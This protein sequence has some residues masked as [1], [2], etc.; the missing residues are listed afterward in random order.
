MILIQL[1]TQLYIYE[2]ASELNVLDIGLKVKKYI[3]DGVNTVE[4]E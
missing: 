4:L 2:T 1:T 3:K